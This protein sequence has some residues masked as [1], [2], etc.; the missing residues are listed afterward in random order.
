MTLDGEC[1]LHEDAFVQ[2]IVAEE[3]T[4]WT[5]W[6]A[7]WLQGSLEVHSG[8]HRRWRDFSNVDSGKL[9]RLV[10]DENKNCTISRK[11]LRRASDWRTVMSEVKR[12]LQWITRGIFLK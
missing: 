1:Q 6:I 12:R 10:Y 3:R 11:H 4:R 8:G 2:R 5:M 9:P 7:E